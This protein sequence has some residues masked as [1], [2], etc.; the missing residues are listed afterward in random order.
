MTQMAQI[1]GHNFVRLP[2]YAYEQHMNVFKHSVYVQYG[3][4][5]QF[6]VAISNHYDIMILF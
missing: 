6:E 1:L 5:K 2:P 4:G 3:C